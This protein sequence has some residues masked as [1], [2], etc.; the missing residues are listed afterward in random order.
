GRHIHHATVARWF[1]RQSEGIVL[2][3]VTQMSLL[4]LLTNPSVMGRDA[5]S[6]SAAWAVVDHLQA[7]SRVEWAD[8]PPYLEMVWRTFSARDDDSH[9]L[10]TDD[11]L[12]AFAQTANLALATLDTG[13]ARRYA[14]VRVDTLV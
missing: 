4:R 14:S 6:R 9:K 3:R 2:C 11:Y 8:E 10:W 5:I 13:F 7:D 1:E 12:A